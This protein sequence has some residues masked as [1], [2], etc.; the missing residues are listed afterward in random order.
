M[1]QEKLWLIE[2]ELPSSS[3]EHFMSGL[4]EFADSMSCFEDDSEE[5][6]QL[7]IYTQT[8]P[9][10]DLLTMAIAGLSFEMEI[11]KPDFI[12]TEVEQID[13]VAES[14]KNFAAVEAGEF[15]VY[16]S[17]RK[18][19]I[20]VDKIAIEIDPKQAFGTGGHETTN[21]CLIAMQELKS[22]FTNI[23]DMGCGS[24]ILAIGAAKLWSNAH[25]IAVDNDPVCVDATIDNAQ[26]NGVYK[27]MQISLSDGYK[28][29]LVKKNAPFDLIIS[30]ILALPLIEFA[31]KAKKSLVAGGYII[32]AGLMA[33]QADSVIHGHEQAGFAFVSNTQYGN[34]SI[35]VM[36]G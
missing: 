30:N 15:F 7:L 23:L 19:E 17:W 2:I 34:W 33:N 36:R 13:W 4:E 26:I 9:D 27:Q 35:L 6:W 1:T 12:I 20:P 29:E 31:P 8:E 25:V 11:A 21:G 18:D 24:G 22:N 14:Q 5:N 32:L 10:K 28:S 3:I 16:P